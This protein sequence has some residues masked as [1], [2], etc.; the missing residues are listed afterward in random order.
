MK[1]LVIGDIHGCYRELLDLLDRAALTKDDRLIAIGDIVNRGPESRRSLAFFMKR[2]PERAFSIMGNHE[3]GHIQAHKR[4][5]QRPPLSTLLARWEFDDDYPDAIAYMKKLPLYLDLPDALLV[6]GYIE[7]GIPLNKQK[8]RVLI[9]TNKA[10]EEL[11]RTYDR[12]WYELYDGDKPLIVGHRDHA[13]DQQPFI[14]RDHVYG[15]DTR[16]VYGGSLTG[17]LLPDFQ[18][19]SV[20]ARRDHWER[21]RTYYLDQRELAGPPDTE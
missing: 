4:G 3:H 19:I 10:E 15:I 8:R 11:A 21:T 20:P 1:T 14:Y 6:H 17:L 5:K 16:C 12:P 13:G 18:L 9:G 7:P 2:A